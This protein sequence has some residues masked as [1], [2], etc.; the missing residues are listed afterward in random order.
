MLYRPWLA[1]LVKLYPVKP[2][3]SSTAIITIMSAF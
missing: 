1:K 2:G 3:F